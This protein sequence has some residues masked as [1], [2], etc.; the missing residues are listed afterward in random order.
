M[1]IL[2]RIRIWSKLSL[3]QSFGHDYFGDL[4]R[5][6]VPVEQK[7]FYLGIYG[8]LVFPFSTTEMGMHTQLHFW[9]MLYYNILCKMNFKQDGNL[10]FNIPS[11]YKAYKLINTWRNYIIYVGIILKGNDLVTVHLN[12]YTKNKWYISLEKIVN[13]HP[14]KIK[15]FEVWKTW[16]DITWYN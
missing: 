7:R 14:S 1:G 9:E 3:F 10:F 15:C 13:S 16:K 5:N 11:T 12:S 8:C 2:Y 4:T 6:S